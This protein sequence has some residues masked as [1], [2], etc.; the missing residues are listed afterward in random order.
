[1]NTLICDSCSHIYHVGGEPQEVRA[2]LRQAQYPCVTP[3]CSGILHVSS[4]VS[5]IRERYKVIHVP[6]RGFF[7]AVHGFGPVSGAPAALD[8]VVETLLT[9]KVSRVEA[10]PV[11]DPERVILRELIFESGIRMHFDSSARGA[12]IYYLEKPGK[13]CVEE[14]EDDLSAAT[15]PVAGRSSTNR[16]ET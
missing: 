7:R 5:A 6:L 3:E 15:E 9:D 10:I 4:C 11:G 1:M 14:V 8:A 13:T 2:L 16:E 12:C